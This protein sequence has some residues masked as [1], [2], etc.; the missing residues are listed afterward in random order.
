MS[1]ESRVSSALRSPSKQALISLITENIEATDANIKAK[2]SSINALAQYYVDQ[3][4]PEKIK[5]IAMKYIGVHVVIQKVSTSSRNQ[6]W[7]R[8][9]KVSSIT[10]PK[11]PTH[12]DCKLN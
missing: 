4:Q 8:L 6:E 10:L 1:Y 11:Y 5:T 2:E 9:S 3:N 12:K 7:P